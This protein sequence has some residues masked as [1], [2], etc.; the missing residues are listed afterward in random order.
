MLFGFY[1]SLKQFANVMFTYLLRIAARI[2]GF[3]KQKR[4]ILKLFFRTSVVI[5]TQYRQGK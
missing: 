1:S 4:R 3:L 5:T 2:S